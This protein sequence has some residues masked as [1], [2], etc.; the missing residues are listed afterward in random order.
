[1]AEQCDG[2]AEERS[3]ALHVATVERPAPGGTQPG[4]CTLAEGR[5]V[6]TELRA[7][8]VRL[9]EVVSE[10]LVDSV[11]RSPSLPASQSA[12]RSCSSARSRFGI[13][14]Y[15]VSRTSTWPKRK[16]SSP[17][18]TARSGRMNSLRTSATR[19]APIAAFPASGSR[20]ETAPRWN[21]RPSM[22][23]RST[24]AR[25]AVP[26]CRASQ[27]GAPAASTELRA[28]RYRSRHASRAV[29]RRTA[30]SPRRR[31]RP[32]ARVRSST[33]SSASTSARLCSSGSGSSAT[34]VA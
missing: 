26:A 16:P 5:R 19:C 25:S 22:E 3:S 2:A 10:Y 12:N 23:P 31:R 24:I 30:G 29:A 27:R 14:S 4:C 6:R 13:E 17:R 9:L 18:N 33:S 1:M 20:S 8:P 28:G 7:V 21:S 15:A 34:R 32:L 11:A